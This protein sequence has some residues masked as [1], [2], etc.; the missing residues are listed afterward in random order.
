MWNSHPPLSLLE[1]MGEG[2]V[3]PY[4]AVWVCAVHACVCMCVWAGERGGRCFHVCVCV[5]VGSLCIG[6]VDASVGVCACAC[7]CT[8]LRLGCASVCLPVFVMAAKSSLPLIIN[9]V[10]RPPGRV[11]WSDTLLRY[12]TAI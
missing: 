9:N 12:C 1:T 6:L 5:Q 11:A 7:V 2:R 8:R 10:F 3:A 4:A